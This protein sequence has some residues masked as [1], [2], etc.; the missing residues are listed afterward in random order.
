MGNTSSNQCSKSD[1]SRVSGFRYD[2]IRSAVLFSFV[3]I[4]KF[5]VLKMVL[6]VV[7][8]TSTVLFQ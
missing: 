7:L 5:P 2:R 1:S 8:V 6:G 3:L 4:I